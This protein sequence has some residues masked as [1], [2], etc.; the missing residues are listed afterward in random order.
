MGGSFLARSPSM[1]VPLCTGALLLHTFPDC[2]VPTLGGSSSLVWLEAYSDQ[3][4]L[5]GCAVPE[6]A[7]ATLDVLEVLNCD[8]EWIFILKR[9]CYLENNH[10]SRLVR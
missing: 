2:S 5:G 3:E 9:G 1:L 4:L 8:L 10:K 7:H 6:A